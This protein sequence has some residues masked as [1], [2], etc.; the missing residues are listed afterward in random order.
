MTTKEIITQLR[1]EGEILRTELTARRKEIERR[2]EE[3]R[4][5]DVIL[6]QLTAKVSEL[7]APE[8]VPEKKGF[9]QRL[10]G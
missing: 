1:S 9:W 4:R 8:E 10:F 3:T 5:R 2:D 6:V 7:P